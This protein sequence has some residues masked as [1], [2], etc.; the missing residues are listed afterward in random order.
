MYRRIL[1][2]TDPKTQSSHS[3]LAVKCHMT[4]VVAL[5]SSGSVGQENFMKELNFLR[6]LLEIVSPGP[7]SS[8]LVLYRD[9]SVARKI[10]VFHIDY[11]LAIIGRWWEP[12]S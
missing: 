8:Y 11:S 3:L 7:F 6:T 12:I 2:F 9:L 5:D 1:K 10:V 4:L